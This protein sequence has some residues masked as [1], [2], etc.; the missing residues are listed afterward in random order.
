MQCPPT[1]GPGLNSINPYGLVAAASKTSLPE[2]PNASAIW[3][4]SLTKAMLT[5]LKVFS[6]ILAASA[7]SGDETS[8]TVSQ[9]LE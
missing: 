1:P 3:A 7:T 9:K 5:C 8:M 2:I 4:N 6:N